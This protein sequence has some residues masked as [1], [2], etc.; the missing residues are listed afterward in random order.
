[1]DTLLY[2]IAGVVLTILSALIADIYKRIGGNRRN[3][4]GAGKE[5][6][7]RLTRLESRV[8][9]DNGRDPLMLTGYAKKQDIE[10]KILSEIKELRKEM[11]DLTV[12]MTRT[13][14]SRERR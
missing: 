8:L 9:S 3:I 13:E 2:W 11:H 1:M 6:I 7:A 12:R 10:D 5:A 14:T 4:T